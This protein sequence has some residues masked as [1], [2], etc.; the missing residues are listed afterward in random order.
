MNDESFQK[1]MSRVS[2]VTAAGSY[3]F[4]LGDC[5]AWLHAPSSPT[6]ATVGVVLCPGLA[7]DG[8][9]THRHLR[10]FAEKLA[11]AGHFVIR[12]DYPGFGDSA[13]ASSDDRDVLPDW[14]AAGRAA[15]DNLY[16]LGVETIAFGGFRLGATIAALSARPKDILLLMSPVISGRSWISRLSLLSS[17]WQ[18]EGHTRTVGGLDADGVVLSPATCD[19]LSKVDLNQVPERL[20]TTILATSGRAG[21]QLAAK[22][23]GRCDA[24]EHIDFPGY[25]EAFDDAL[26]NETPDALFADLIARLGGLS[27]QS[28]NAPIIPPK[29]TE[30][31]GAGWR[32]TAVAFQPAERSMPLYGNLARPLTGVTPASRG[33]IFLNT[34]GDPRSGGGRFSVQ[35]SRRLAAA[36]HV[37]LRFDFAGLGDSPEPEGV[38]RTHAYETPRLEEIEAA[39]QLVAAEGVSDLYLFGVS[40][41]AY[42]AFHAALNSPRLKGAFCVSQVEYIWRPGAKVTISGNGW[43]LS[44][45]HYLTGALRASSWRR[46]LNGEVSVA[47]VT[48][49]MIVNITASWANRA[50]RREKKMLMRSLAKASSRGVKI[51]CVVGTKDPALGALESLFGL[52]GRL[53]TRSKGMTVMI[54]EDIDHGLVYKNSRT[55]A[56][57]ELCRWLDSAHVSVGSVLD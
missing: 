43:R 21:E 10:V 12:F 3:P 46:V 34:G 50:I 55:L 41:G 13:D 31:T 52:G 53:L 30:L 9:W 4:L 33:V 23:A 19:S 17:H 28:P 20:P 14:I 44:T 51:H 47:R 26:L 29:P 11:L 8:R 42:H 5:S 2:P 27:S 54:N 24:F 37:C 40:A 35:A 56:F 6:F 39:L 32:E 45:R 25:K 18:A 38:R 22:L 16:A 49:D 57:R 15:A 36:G 1:R 48:K 7:R